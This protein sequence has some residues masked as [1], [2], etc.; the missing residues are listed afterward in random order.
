MIGVTGATGNLGRIV[1]EVLRERAGEVLAFGREQ[2]DYDKPS[3]LAEAFHGV[4]RLLFISSPELDPGR[5]TAQHLA[6]VGAAAEAGVEA[7]VYTSFHRIPGIFAVH[8]LTEDAIAASGMAYSILRNPFYTEP[9]VAAA[10]THSAGG[11]TAGG[12]SVEGPT[13]S[14]RGRSVE[15]STHSAGG[16]SAGELTHS[17]GGQSAGGQP[18]GGES[19]GEL[20]HA[21]GGQPLNTAY[22]ADLAEAAAGALLSDRIANRTYELNGPLWTFPELAA[23]RGTTAREG[24]VA[25]PMGWLHGFAKA[26]ALAT[27]T[28]DLEE[29]LGRPAR[30]PR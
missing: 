27:Q 6:V 5:R 17:A 26:G 24:E 20:T 11:H 14:S 3:T 7:V 9:F 2:A 29:L 18:A 15:G 19:V 25:G 22:R 21:T 13:H 30:A 4:S 16:R 12:R 10:P 28:P 1:V 23:S 8:G